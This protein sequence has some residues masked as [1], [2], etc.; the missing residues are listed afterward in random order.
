MKIIE[1]IVQFLVAGISF[2]ASIFTIILAVNSD[3]FST[4]FLICG[5]VA[6]AGMTYL[7]VQLLIA[8]N[9]FCALRVLAHRGKIH[10]TY[11][12]I[13]LDFLKSKF[14]SIY[15]NEP[16][17]N[18][19]IIRGCEFNFQYKNS[20][21][22]YEGVD[23]D[24]HHCFRLKGHSGKL[25]ML[26][27]H[28]GG[29]L[30]R[31]P[32]IEGGDSHLGTYVIYQGKKYP[33]IP[34][35]CVVNLNNQRNQVLDRI[36][37]S[38]PPMIHD[39]EQLEL[40]YQNEGGTNLNESATFVIC[41][42]NYGKKFSGGATVCV[43]YERPYYADIQLM[44]LP[45][46]SIRRSKMKLVAKFECRDNG[47]HY[48]C[49]ID[50]IDIKS[51]YFV[52]IKR[53]SISQTCTGGI[54]MNRSGIIRRVRRN[55]FVQVRE[56]IRDNYFLAKRS[57]PKPLCEMAYDGLVQGKWIGYGCFGDH[58]DLMSYLDYKESVSGEIEV[59]ICL[60]QDQFKG[61]GLMKL[62][63]KFLASRYPDREITIGTY[64]KNAG[65]IC[66]IKS[67]GFEEECKTPDDRIDGSATI[68]YRRIPGKIVVSKTAAPKANALQHG[69]F[70]DN[71][72]R[73]K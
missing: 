25:D 55:E 44:Q 48:Q 72:R 36:Q 24:Y 10:T 32:V 59:G 1:S 31:R 4:A 54:G 45:Y 60:T 50:S 29:E 18:G 62:M 22:T 33:V 70:S 14:N 53:L 67:A 13:Y 35:P 6:L 43:T 5:I 61:R 66:C 23:I 56:A 28:A 40:Y 38:L 46:D 8:N 63:L 26:L 21:E 64:E 17:T 57:W 47:M 65:M 68:H 16:K 30:V 49:H 11:F 73:K 2:A 7:Y 42:Q 52:N 3:G 20:L 15:D 69:F 9:K 19:L 37:C 41:P 58:G 51:I 12:M 27:L 39:E 34:E 71:I